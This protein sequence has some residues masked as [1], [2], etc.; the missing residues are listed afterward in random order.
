MS[1]AISTYLAATGCTQRN[2]QTFGRYSHSIYFKT[3]SCVSER[4]G[5]GKFC[6]KTF[7]S[8][9][10]TDKSD[11]RKPGSRESRSV[12][13]L[14]IDLFSDSKTRRIVSPDFQFEKTERVCTSQ[15]LSTV[16]PFSS[17]F[18]SSAQR[19]DG[20]VRSMPS[21]FPSAYTSTA[22]QVSQGKLQRHTLPNDLPTLWTVRSSR[23]FRFC[24]QLDSGTSQKPQD[25]LRS[26]PGRLSTGKSVPRAATTTGQN[27]NHFTTIPRMDDQLRKICS[28]SDTTPRV[29]RRYLGHSTQLQVPVGTE[30][31][32]A[33]QCT[34]RT[35][36]QLVP[37]TGPVPNGETQLCLVR[38]PEGKTPLSDNAVLQQEAAEITT[39]QTIQD[40]G[41]SPSR[42]EL[43]GND[44]FQFNTLTYGTHHTSPHH[45]RIRCGVGSTTRADVSIRSVDDDGT[46]ELARQLQRAVCGLPSSSTG[47]AASEKCP[48]TPADRQSHCRGLYKQGGWH[49]VQ[50]TVRTDQTAAGS[51]RLS[52]RK[53]DGSVLPRAVQYRSRCTITQEDEPRV[54]LVAAG[55]DCRVPALGKA[56]GRSFCFDNSSRGATVRIDRST[57]RTSNISQRFSRLL[58]LRT[59]LAISSAQLGAPSVKSPQRGARQVHTDSAEVGE[60]VLVGGPAAESHSETASNTEPASG[61]GRHENGSTSAGG[62]QHVPR[63][64][65]D[66]RWADMI[67]DW[68]EQEKSLFLSSWRQSTIRTYL[69]AWNKWKRWCL[70]NSFDFKYPDPSKVAK[71]LAHLHIQEG[72]AYRT[73]LVHKSVIATFTKT[74]EQDVSSNFLVKQILRAISVKKVKAS[75]PPIWD[76]R[77]VLVYL[78]NNSPDENNFYQVS[79]RVAVLLMLASSRRVHDL[80]LLRIGP[81]YLI[82]QGNSFEMWPVFGSKTDNANRRQSGWKIRN[83]PDQNL[84]AVYWIRRL[85]QV[86]QQRRNEG[87]W[88]EL[89]IT[90]RGQCKPATKTIIGGWIKAVLREAGVEASPG[91]V[92]SAVSSLNWLENF[93]IDKILSTG[94]WRQEH[95]FNN[96]YC[97]P[98]VSNSTRFVSN[99]SLSQYFEAI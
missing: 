62:S 55:D 44:G 64:L 97:R 3:T 51:P 58:G 77:S 8:N 54:A 60:S 43:V 39:P 63:G 5:N 91:S 2:L 26:I 24:H 6:N 7:F 71:Y 16:Q 9:D 41:T 27:Y 29:S 67:R 17:T 53:F 90:T 25:P 13:Q 20:K 69:P 81:A 76:P 70:S 50:E 1:F 48:R 61:F 12:T 59:S 10:S 87:N 35:E 15:G 85:V 18:I 40:T 34:T 37:Q 89:F 78:S 52:K 30:V 84:N 57:R 36:R 42:Y 94:N 83:H 99:V 4:L 14:P 73:I 79:Q 74:S 75:K 38:H 93:P 21:V 86:S 11:D 32:N 65:A 82:D 98:I 19:L 46:T 68:T 45:G 88:A 72:L 22:P 66:T 80:T 95:T 92:R 28:G 56:R 49:E 47:A 31:P 96:Y 23:Y 33:P